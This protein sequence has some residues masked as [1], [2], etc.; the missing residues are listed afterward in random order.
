[1]IGI[2]GQADAAGAVVLAH[3][4]GQVG[5]LFVRQAR[6]LLLQAGGEGGAVR[7]GAE[8]RRVTQLVEPVG[9]AFRRLFRLVAAQPKAFEIDQAGNALRANPGIDAGGVAAQAVA[10]QAHR[11]L[12]GE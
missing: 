7:V 12:S 5:G 3:V 9:V 10:D 2:G 8:A 11:F 6:I 1:V 4:L